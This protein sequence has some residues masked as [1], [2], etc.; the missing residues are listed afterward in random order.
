MVWEITHCK[1]KASCHG[2][3]SG[4]TCQLAL[5]NAFYLQNP[6]F[7]P[8]FYFPFFLF[9]FFPFF[10][11]ADRSFLESPAFNIKFAIPLYCSIYEI[12]FDNSWSKRFLRPPPPYTTPHWD[13]IR[14]LSNLPVVIVFSSPQSKETCWWF[15]LPSS[16]VGGQGDTTIC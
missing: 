8:W 9:L 15:D 6:A 14:V 10:L 4:C 1:S 11:Y 16:L 13:K 3:F 2:W 12:F 5:A 7:L